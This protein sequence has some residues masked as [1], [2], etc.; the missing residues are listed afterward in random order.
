MIPLTKQDVIKDFE[1]FYGSDPS[2]RCLDG[3]DRC[4]YRSHDGDSMCAV[5]KWL[6]FGT[7]FKEAM[8][9]LSATDLI[10]DNGEG[11]AIFKEEVRH[12]RDPNFWQDLQRMHDREVNWN[13]EGLTETGKGLLNALKE[14]HKA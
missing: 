1:D 8:N 10:H 11:C 4:R 6:D 7:W 2:R 5:G 3:H 13:E 12:I 14:R 9:E